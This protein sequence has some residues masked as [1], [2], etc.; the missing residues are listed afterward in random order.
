MNN[1]NLYQYIKTFLVTIFVTFLIVIGFM[2][3]IKHNVYQEEMNRQIEDDSIDY[4]LI[5]LLIEKNRYQEEQFPKNYKINLRL[6]VLYEIQRDFKNSEA[7]FKKSILK[8]PYNEFRPSY[9]LAA[10]YVRLGRYNE[11]ETL[12]DNIKE[13]PDVELINYK[14]EIYNRL[15]DKYYNAGAYEEAISRYKK[16]L[17]YY[18]SINS[19]KVASVKGS[20]ASSFVYLADEKVKKLQIDEA[21]NSL[22]TA[23]AIIN[24]PVIR[25]KLAILLINKDPD[26]AYKYFDEVFK[27]EPAILN[28]DT[29]YN[30]LSQ[31]A[32]KADAEGNFAQAELYRFKIRK[33]K[34]FYKSNILSV[35]DIEVENPQGKINFSRWRNKYKINFEFSLKNVSELNINSLYIEIVFK[36]GETVL[37]TYTNQ[38]ADSKFI[39]RPDTST[40]DVHIKTMVSPSEDEIRPKQINV[41]IFASK[42]STSY[43]MLIY[44]MILREHIKNARSLF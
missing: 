1:K 20:L 44:E 33:L 41:Q 28:Y 21:I 38:I 29:Y 12:M 26:L 19:A 40:P 5:G 37:D 25:Y 39:L 17:F 32:A 4:Y 35:S 42:N 9:K 43:K 10:L 15:G 11:A 36:D 18:S 14:A 6:G 34:E 30:F 27:K 16:A 8:A 13:R 7:E 22:Q 31:R 24:A 3:V 2:F 23:T